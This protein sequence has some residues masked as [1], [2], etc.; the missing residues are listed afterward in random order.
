MSSS[1]D[2][3]RARAFLQH[4]AE[5]TNPILA[6]YVAEVGPVDAAH[7]VSER[8]A[9][10][11][12]LT[13]T[14]LSANWIRAEAG[15]RTAAELGARFVIPE[16]DEWPTEIF[17]GLRV[18]AAD[19]STLAGPP[20]GLW[21]RGEPRLDELASAHSV[22]IVGARAATE[23]GEHHAAEFA[24]ALASRN[25]TVFSG[26]A[27]GI[28][29]AAHR[30]A[31]ATDRPAATIAVLPCGIDSAYPAGHVGLLQRIA[32]AGAIVSEYPPGVPP[33]RHR[34]LQ[35]HRLLAALTT[36][37][38]VVEAGQRSGARHAARLAAELGR[39]VLAIPG[40]VSSAV[41]AGCHKLIQDG[42]A[43]L[44]TSADE[45]IAVLDESEEVDA[46]PKAAVPADVAGRS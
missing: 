40:P 37:T 23:Y 14:R 6:R 43:R 7:H 15:L 18:L 4:A 34:F 32:A 26:A 45:V 29:G 27:Y 17:D 8:T 1:T 41:S 42:T 12:V 5:P 21:V 3:R 38:V 16:D 10:A 28:D 11:D 2:A 24:Y 39:P 9:S 25:V 13:E 36:A 35:R 44:V 30:G 20:L 31:L 22:A 46:D 33:A 19:D